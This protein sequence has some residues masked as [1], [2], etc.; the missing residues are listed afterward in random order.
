MP[1]LLESLTQ[2]LNPDIVGQLG[3]AAGLDNSST[4]KGLA[5]VGP[6]LTGA[7]ASSASTPSGLDGLL[8]ATG[9]YRNGVLLTPVT[10][11][12]LAEVL[13]TGEL[14]AEA[15]DFTP[16]RFRAGAARALLEQPV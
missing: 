4:A 3:K 14:P 10:G 7:L 8:L 2:A 16:L 15:R 11:D 5:V 13:T 1:S 12:V 9:H 6:L